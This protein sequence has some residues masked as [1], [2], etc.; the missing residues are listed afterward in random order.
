MEIYWFEQTQHDLPDDNDWLSETELATLGK[1]RFPKRRADWRLGRWTAKR[2][3]AAALG[4]S[5]D[6][7][8]LRNI[9]IYPA[10]TGE[11]RVEVVG[12]RKPITISLSHRDGR[13][14]CAVAVG[15]LALGCDLE[16]VEPKS[17]AFIVDYFTLEEQELVSKIPSAAQPLAASLVWSAKESALKALHVGLRA[18]TRSVAVDTSLQ[19]I[20][21]AK[22]CD[23]HP[24]LIPCNGATPLHGWWRCEGNVLRTVVSDADH[25]PPLTLAARQ[26]ATFL[27]VA[28]LKRQ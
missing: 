23:W 18:D 15:T 4:V 21:A 19:N 26:P 27:R 16:L 1:L 7:G 14:A 12:L 24:L 3:V 10:A 8:S 6:Q 28:Q 9:V 2:G 20:A 17:V 25:E 22:D 5:G 11:P 13:A